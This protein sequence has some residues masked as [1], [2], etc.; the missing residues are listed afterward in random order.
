MIER[1]RTDSVPFLRCGRCRE[2]LDEGDRFCPSCGGEAPDEEHEPADRVT[3]RL[4]ECAG[5]GAALL[6]ELEAQGLRCAFCGQTRLEEKG[7]PRIPA[8]RLIVPFRIDRE[9]AAALCRTW[10]ERGFFRP[11]GLRRPSRG[12]EMRGV[13]LPYWQLSIDGHAYWTAD[14][15]HVPP[16]ARAEWAP[17]FGEHA[18]RYAGPLLS[19]SGVLRPFIHAGDAWDL[20]QASPWVPGALRGH[21]AEAFSVPRKRL[22]HFALMGIEQRLRED[23][24]TQVPGS[25]LRG[26]KIN[27]LYTRAHASPV[28]MPA[29]IAASEYRGRTYYFVV[30]GQSGK[31]QGS[32]PVSPW[33]VLALVALI[34][35][36][37]FLIGLILGGR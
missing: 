37:L 33:R 16:G 31:V 29:W 22:R 13:Y 35:L 28:L 12:M 32:T 3:V 27:P 5:C 7:L 8:P 30:N 26:L 23:C 34:L 11:G 24:E 25:E 36:V 15:N 18:G 14:S 10:L 1:E 9:Q 17:H 19:A 21:P 6:W 2:S 4:F 20:S